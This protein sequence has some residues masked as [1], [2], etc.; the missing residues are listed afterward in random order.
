MIGAEKLQIEK[1]AYHECRYRRKESPATPEGK[2]VP[3]AQVVTMAAAAIAPNWHPDPHG[4]VLENTAIMRPAFSSV[5]V[6]LRKKLQDELT[7]EARHQ[8]IDLD[9]SCSEKTPHLVE[10]TEALRTSLRLIFPRLI[11]HLKFGAGEPVGFKVTGAATGNPKFAQLVAATAHA[12]VVELGQDS[13]R[14]NWPLVLRW[15]HGELANRTPEPAIK[16]PA[17][18]LSG[19]KAKTKARVPVQPAKPI[20]ILP[21]PI[22]PEPA[23]PIDVGEHEWDLMP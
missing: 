18:T 12:L 1:V 20:V 23:A 6:A 21:A 10:H 14:P 5:G 16:A 3:F 15:L 4:D 11:M 7:H 9:Y 22:L 19:A 2:M 13:V 17:R 8:V